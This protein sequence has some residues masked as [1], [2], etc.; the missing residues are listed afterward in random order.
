MQDA[1]VFTGNGPTWSELWFKLNFSLRVR[2]QV[3]VK[4]SWINDV[5]RVKGDFSERGGSDQG[6][7]D[8]DARR[9]GIIYRFLKFKTVK[10]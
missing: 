10:R 4:E 1:A 6:S 7:H 8:E 2:A 9:K 5:A 3:A